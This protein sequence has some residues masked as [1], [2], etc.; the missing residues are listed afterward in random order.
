VPAEFVGRA[1][2]LREKI[3]KAQGPYGK[4]VEQL[5]RPLR[6]RP[7][8]PPP[9]HPRYLRRL[10]VAV[11]AAARGSICSLFSE[12]QTG[13]QKLS[14]SISD[15]V[16]TAETLLL[17]GW[18]SPEPALRVVLHITECQRRPF[19]YAYSAVPLGVLGLHALSRRFERG[20]PNGD[21]DVLSDLRPLLGAFRRAIRTTAAEFRI[22]TPASGGAWLG[23]LTEDGASI[24]VRTFVTS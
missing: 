19:S 18:C 3:A 10:A 23:Q 15:L 5:I 24:A 20:R 13:K 12:I 21:A 4:A 22:A 14:I 7:A 17:P 9:T 2:A 16:V 6:P 1:R 8:W 11:D